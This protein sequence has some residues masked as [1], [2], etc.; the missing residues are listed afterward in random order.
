MIATG[1]TCIPA[2]MESIDAGVGQESRPEFSRLFSA[3][4]RANGPEFSRVFRA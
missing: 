1:M 4:R 2:A 3:I